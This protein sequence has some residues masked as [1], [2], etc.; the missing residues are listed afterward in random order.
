MVWQ[1][2]ALQYADRLEALWYS[3]K[4]L[5]LLLAGV[6][7]TFTPIILYQ[8]W[9]VWQQLGAI[10]C[11]LITAT[12]IWFFSSRIPKT[13]RGKI[14]IVMSIAVSNDPA[15]ARARDRFYEELRQTA[16]QHFPGKFQL[17]IVP[18][19]YARKY[20]ESGDAAA[21]RRKTRGHY[22]VIGRCKAGNLRGARNYVFQLRATVGN[23]EVADAVRDEL[24]EDFKSFFPSRLRVPYD[25]DLAGFE[26]AAIHMTMLATYICGFAAL[27]SGDL[28]TAETILENLMRNAPTDA[29]PLMA[30]LKT[31]ATERLALCYAISIHVL[32]EAFRKTC[33]A[34]I[35]DDIEQRTDKLLA[36]NPPQRLA[37]YSGRIR[38]CI[39]V[40]SVHSFRRK[41]TAGSG[42]NRPPIPVQIDR[43]KT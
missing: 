16:R 39:P 42:D 18:E 24:R 36:I 43:L 33:D 30:S 34:S 41:S 9:L 25:N 27:I 6:G 40:E 13:R 37:A 19:Y 7:V 3:P 28:N 14:G 15:A 5:C 26:F 23:R 10:L 8:D 20:S 38:P 31:K 21:L 11:L 12:T 22:C 32:Y 1:A 29:P 17:I 4:G 35:L 2:D